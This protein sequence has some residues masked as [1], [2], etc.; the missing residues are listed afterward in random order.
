MSVKRTF[1][2]G[3]LS[4]V[5]TVHCS[6]EHPLAPK[7]DDNSN[8]NVDL[9]TN[10]TT[11]ISLKTKNNICML[12]GTLVKMFPAGELSLMSACAPF[13][14]LIVQLFYTFIS[15]PVGPAPPPY[16]SWTADIILPLTTRGRSSTPTTRV[17]YCSTLDH[18]WA[19]IERAAVYVWKLSQFQDDS[20]KTTMR[21]K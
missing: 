13:I 2:T 19:W 10:L 5:F 7:L 15:G 14:A 16:T 11:E 20:N 1:V 12:A 8:P 18:C 6:S 4:L 17:G 3:I 21:G 9:L